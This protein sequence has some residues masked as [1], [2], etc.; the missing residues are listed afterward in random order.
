MAKQE[1]RFGEIEL[2]L[3]RTTGIVDKKNREQQQVTEVELEKIR[4]NLKEEINYMRLFMKD[5]DKK[6]GDKVSDLEHHVM[7]SRD[8][9]LKTKGKLEDDLAITCSEIDKKLMSIE[10]LD[11]KIELYGGQIEG[12]KE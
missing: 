5:V 4:R 8:M 9:L 1:A 2:I 7:S 11:E 10:I 3:N 12:V 6:T